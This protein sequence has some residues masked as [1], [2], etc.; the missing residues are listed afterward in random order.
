VAG[1]DNGFA[2]LDIVEQPGQVGALAFQAWIS[3]IV[4]RF[5]RSGS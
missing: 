4:F 2:A 5:G 1:D 3:R